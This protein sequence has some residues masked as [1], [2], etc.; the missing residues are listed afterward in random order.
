[1][2]S[3]I[4]VTGTDTDVGK[5]VFAAALAGALGGAYWKPVEA[6]SAPE[7]DAATVR[8]L[9]ELP[10][11]HV[12]PEIY[13]LST[14]ASPHLVAER[15]GITIDIERIA[16]LPAA[17]DGV[18]LIIESAG[19][20]LVPLTRRHLQIDLFA[21]WRAP[22]VLVAGTRFGTINHSLLSIE[23]LRRRGIPVLG[24]AFVDEANADSE[25]TIAEMGRV[26]RLGRLPRLD[27]LDAAALRT[28]FAANFDIA[29]FQTPVSPHQLASQM[30]P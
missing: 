11:E 26:R 27:R 13:R 3:T 25:L 17:S 19:G 22:T 2:N 1:M 23:A 7:T 30:D 12:H 29:D 21:R 20:L 15:D 18:P 8:R 5:T 14:A 16:R 6:G 10:E 28:A 9:A 24:I 4:I